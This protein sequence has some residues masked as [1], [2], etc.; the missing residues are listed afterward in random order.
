MK[1]RLLSAALAW[2]AAG[3]LAPLHAGTIAFPDG[4][5][6]FVTLQDALDAAADGDVVVIAPGEYRGNFTLDDKLGVTLKG[7]GV[8]SIDAR[9]LGA[10]G[11]GPALV[12]TNCPGLRIEGLSFRN[13]AGADAAG[14]GLRVNG[15]DAVTLKKLVVTGCETYGIL[16][17][18][19]EGL[20]LEECEL[21]GNVGGVHLE[22]NQAELRRVTVENDGQQGI[23]VF[24]DDATI[25]RSVVAVIRGGGGINISGAR[26]T[27]RKCTVTAVL[28]QGT[29]GIATSGG[30][31]DLRHNR[32]V[33]CDV[34]MFVIYGAEGVVKGNEFVRC[35]SSG[36]RLGNVSHTLTIKGNLVSRCGGPGIWVE[37]DFQYLVDNR[38]EECGDDGFR[39][40]GASCVLEG[41]RAIGNQRDGIDIDA[42]AV[43]VVLEQNVVKRNGAEGIDNSGTDTH[44]LENVVTKNRIDFAADGTHIDDGGN[45]FEVVGAPGPEI[46]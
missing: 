5:A 33:G 15:S 26:P 32:V 39:V 1:P 41:N 19:C 37:G 36:L 4:G 11:S 25:E 27:I 13:A 16:A 12:A 30:N 20:R 23:T 42:S 10:T 31:P 3:G 6:G 7:N 2:L 38:V 18:Q 22:G 40:F 46:D 28:D 43:G 14:A 29:S 24:G 44:L 21:R 45:S 35:S 34:G 8:V 9:P 17:Q